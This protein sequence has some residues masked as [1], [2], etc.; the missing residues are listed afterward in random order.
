VSQQS[1]PKVAAPDPSSEGGTILSLLLENL[2]DPN[3]RARV[4]AVR[5]ATDYTDEVV[6][7]RVLALADSDPDHE[8][9]CAAISSL[10]NFVYLGATTVYELERGTI[11]AEHLLAEADYKRVYGFLLSLYRDESRTLDERRYAVEALSYASDEAVEELIA[12]L[13][14]RPEK[15][16][17]ISALFAMGCSGSAR[18]EET[19]ATEFMNE[20]SDLQI[21]AI[22]AAGE[23]GAEDL[24]KDLWRMTYAEDKDVVMAAIWA[25]GQTGWAGAFDRLDELTLD[26]DPQIREC[27]DEAMEEWLF[28]NGL[29]QETD[30]DEPDTFLDEV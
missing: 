6:V 29:A 3:P 22:H 23:M 15:E 21:E 25:L 12:E 11:Y 5:E 1:G 4:L 13:Y 16:A 24:G 28:Y 9:R 18:W 8:V 2:D 14:A 10:G 26:E 19:L 17:K 20:D 27:A 30:L 7:D